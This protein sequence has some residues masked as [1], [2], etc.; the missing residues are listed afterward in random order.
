MVWRKK[1]GLDIVILFNYYIE[2]MNN[3]QFKDNLYEQFARISKALAHPKRLELIDMLSQGERSVEALAHE[4]NM[5]IANT[6]QHL[7]TLKAAR[8]I[9]TRKD[10]L[11][12]YYS[13][14][15][16]HVHKLWSLIRDL[17]QKSLADVDRVVQNFLSNRQQFQSVSSEEL[18][19]LMQKRDV[20]VLDVRPTLEY[21]EGHIKGA[22]SVP[23]GELKNYLA[24]IPKNKKIVAYC[25]G[26]YCIMSFD[27]VKLMS[28]KGYHAVRLDEGLPEW[29]LRG[30]PIE[31]IN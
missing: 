19:V 22:I 5:S 12:A 26:P 4:T 1:L 6:S 31:K 9:N 2:Y 13:L 21:R 14:A 25:R 28:A 29:R 7:Q 15:D 10:G 30:F 8:L 11:Y 23:L 3:R 27:A 24:K 16:I 17:G 18:L 20:I